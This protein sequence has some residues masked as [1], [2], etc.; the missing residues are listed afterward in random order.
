[1]R[2][3]H[4]VAFSDNHEESQWFVDNSFEIAKIINDEYKCFKA[5]RA[6]VIPMENIQEGYFTMIYENTTGFKSDSSFFLFFLMNT[7]KDVSKC[8]DTPIIDHTKTIDEQKDMIKNWFNH[9]VFEW[10]GNQLGIKR[11]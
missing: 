8:Y 7:G 2:D 1:M 6:N 9:C 11:K 4:I 5:C 3:L 10:F